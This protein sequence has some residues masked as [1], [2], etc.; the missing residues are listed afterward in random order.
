MLDHGVAQIP[1]DDPARPRD[2][3]GAADQVQGVVP[4]LDIAKYAFLAL[5]LAAVGYMIYRRWDD[6]RRLAR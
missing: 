1:L 6:A 3:Q 5:T 2:H 4:Y